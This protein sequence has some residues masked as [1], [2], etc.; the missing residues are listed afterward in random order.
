MSPSHGSPTKGRHLPRTAASTRMGSNDVLARRG[1]DG[2]DVLDFGGYSVLVTGGSSGIG[3][4]IATAFRD[5]GAEVTATG[6]RARGDYDSD[7]EGIDFRTVDVGDDGQ[8]RA[9]AD[10]LG[11]LD[12]LVNNAGMVRYRRAEYEPETFRRVLDVNLTAGLHLATLLRPKLAR[13]PGSIINLSSMTAF[14]G[15][16]GNPA[17]GASKAGVVQMTRTLAVAFGG[18]GIRVNAVAPGYVH[19]QMTDRFKRNPEADTGIVARTPLGR[20]S[21]AEDQAKVALFLASDLAGFVTGQTITVDGGF[22]CSL[23]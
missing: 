8:T 12:V 17:Y 20:W 14:F 2:G 11:R 18:D 21:T 5:A 6:T 23:G 22:G 13:R 10:S 19:T 3:N 4:A 15:S 16:Q 7:L 9:L 1:W